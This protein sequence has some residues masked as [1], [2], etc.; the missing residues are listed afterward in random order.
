MVRRQTYQARRPSSSRADRKSEADAA[1]AAFLSRGGAVTH[2]ASVVPTAFA[3]KSCGHTGIAG[4]T[5][6][7]TLRCPKCREPLL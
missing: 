4:V 3:C 6:G 5:Q 1:L 2:G 7:K